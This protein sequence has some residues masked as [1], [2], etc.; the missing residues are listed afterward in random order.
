M[1][2]HKIYRK[3]V[4]L[5][6]FLR[7]EMGHLLQ[8]YVAR[9]QERGFC[10]VFETLEILGSIVEGF[11]VPLKPPHVDYLT[12]ILLPL[13]KMPA[14]VLYHSPLLYCLLQFTIKVNRKKKKKIKN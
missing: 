11:S 12:R 5:R 7:E 6:T 13:A 2:L 4:H 9:P 10:G 8:D 1:A 14:F 3:F